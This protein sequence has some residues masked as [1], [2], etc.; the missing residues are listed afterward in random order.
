[1]D[2]ITRRKR[3]EMQKDSYPACKH[4]KHFKYN[5]FFL[6][7]G[8]IVFPWMWLFGSGHEVKKDTIRL[9]KCRHPNSI[10]KN[11]GDFFMGSESSVIKEYYDTGY[12]RG[13][14]YDRTC[15]KY[16]KLFEP[17]K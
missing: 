2:N 1:M 16:G 5:K 6:I 13:L 11:N 4:C 3:K 14:E 15:G 7:L 17:K 10:I 8:W 9:S 12:M